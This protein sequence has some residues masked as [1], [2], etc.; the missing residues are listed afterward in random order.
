[1]KVVSPP[2][3]GQAVEFRA[4]D[5]LYFAAATQGTWDIRQTVRKTPYPDL[6]LTPK[7]RTPPPRQRKQEMGMREANDN[8]SGLKAHPLARSRRSRSSSAPT[9]APAC[10][11]MAYAARKVGYVPLLVCLALTCLF[12]IVTMLYVTEARLRTRGNN[13]LSGPP[14]VTWA[15]GGWLIF[16]AVA[17]NSTGPWS[18]HDRQRQHH[19]RVLRPVR[20]SRA[21]S[22]A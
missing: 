13:Q 3:E 1:M 18:P 19:A 9:S 6:R 15:F 14:G 11:S 12:C 20:P 21:R 7:N 10:W 16:T 17:A 22:A 5:A 8:A 2:D 4:G